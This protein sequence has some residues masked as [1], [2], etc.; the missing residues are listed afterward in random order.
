MF[1][2]ARPALLTWLGQLASLETLTWLIPAHYE[3][4]VACSGRQLEA[5]AD[6][7]EARPW[8]SSGGNWA[9]LAGVD[10]ALLRFGLVPGEP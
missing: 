7:L 3:A 9:F 5:L 2:R 10:R 8:A 4:P 6:E 1:P